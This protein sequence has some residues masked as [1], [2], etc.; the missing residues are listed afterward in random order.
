VVLIAIA[1]PSSILTVEHGLLLKTIRV[2]QVIRF[3]SIFR[4]SKIIVYRD[5][6]TELKRHED[7]LL[8]FSKIHNYLVTPPYLRRKL[9]S[10]D[11]DLKYV[12]VLPPL[13]LLVYDVSR[14]GFVGEKRVGFK[15]DGYVDI[16]LKRKFKIIDPGKCVD[17]KL[18]YVE[19][20]SINP[21]L[22][23]CTGEKPYL[24]PTL[25]SADSLRDV[26]EYGVREGYFI[27]A[28]SKHGVVPSLDDLV[29]LKYLE[30][31]LVLYG[32]PKYGLYEISK[33]EGF[34]LDALV[35]TVWN[36]IPGQ[37][38]KTVRTEEALI[39][40]LSILN[41]FINR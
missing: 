31:I 30:K 25:G 37:G 16:G 17:G 1:I 29:R 11:N 27:I 15:I 38:V 3:S 40:S 7:Y 9:V 10:I 23:E 13:R 36:I 22:V 26:I 28:T 14:N 18:V 39:A 5:P 35:N 33:R 12:G 4:V 2:F 34:E 20:K 21:P 6:F 32:A 24:G 19:I 41:M 8:L